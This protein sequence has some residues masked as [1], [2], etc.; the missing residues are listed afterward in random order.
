MLDFVEQ[1]F[2]GHN[3][4]KLASSYSQ[5]VSTPKRKNAPQKLSI[6]YD[7]SLI[8]DLEKENEVLIEHFGRAIKDG[9]IPRNFTLLC[10]QLNE[11]KVMFQNHLLKENVKLF[12]YLEQLM[13]NNSKSLESLRKFRKETNHCSNEV[14]NFCKKYEQPMEI[15]MMQDAFEKEYLKVGQTLIHRVQLIESEMHSQYAS[16]R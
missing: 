7:N 13:K 5:T 16:T 9:F 10:E 3:E 15:L 14:I 4:P 11:F 2:Q 6:A 1:L 12:C 8:G